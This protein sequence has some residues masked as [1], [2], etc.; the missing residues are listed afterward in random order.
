MR[1]LKGGMIVGFL[2]ASIGLGLVCALG[3][4]ASEVTPEMAKT[5]V[6]NW[7]AMREPMGCKFGKRAA[8]ARRCEVGGA[9]FNVVK[10]EEGGFVVTSAD[11]SIRPIVFF[12]DG[13]D[14]DEDP[15]NPLYALLQRDLEVCAKAAADAAAATGGTPVVPVAGAATL[16]SVKPGGSTTGTTGVSPVAGTAGTTGTT[17]VSPVAGT[18]DPTGTTGVSPVASA[19]EQ[20]WAELLSAPSAAKLAGSVTPSD[21]RVAQI[22]QSKWNQGSGIYNYYTPSN[23]VCGCVATAT[24]QLMR[25]FQYP[26]ASVASFTNPNC[27]VNGTA[28]TL[29]SQGGTFDWSNMPLV[30][31][32]PNTTQ[33]Q[34][35]GK[36]CSDVGIALSMSY[37][38]GGSGSHCTYVPWVLVNRFGYRGAV[39]VN[40]QNANDAAPMERAR[41]AMITNFDA[42]LPV[43]LGVAGN[44]GHAIVGDGYGY[45]GTNF[46]CHVNMGWSGSSDGWYIPPNIGSFT[47][48]DEVVYNIYTTQDP[49]YSIVSGR[50]L[51]SS[52]S[53]ATSQ[54]VVAKNS[55]YKVVATTTTNSK[56]IFA[57]FLQPGTY[58][59]VAESG[60]YRISASATPTAAPAVGTSVKI[61]DGNPSAAYYNNSDVCNAHVGDLKLTSTTPV[62]RIGSQNYYSFGEACYEA[63]AGQTVTLL[64]DVEETVTLTVPA[65]VDFNGHTLTGA[66]YC[67][68]NTGTAI[69][70][71]GTITNGFDGKPGVADTFPEGTV[72][73]EDMTVSGTIWSDSHPLIFAGGTYTGAIRSGS[74]ACTIIDG[75]FTSLMKEGTP[76]FVIQGGHF[77]ADFTAISSLPNQYYRWLQDATNADYPWYVTGAI[78]YATPTLADD[79]TPGTNFTSAVVTCTVNIPYRGTDGAA[80]LRVIATAANGRAYTNLVALAA[81]TGT[82]NVSTTF[83]AL[84]PAASYAVTAEV[85]FGDGSTLKDVTMDVEVMHAARKIGAWIDED[86]TTFASN[87]KWTV[88]SS[89]TSEV[90]DG[91]LKFMANNSPA[92]AVRYTPT[93]RPYD[94][95][96]EVMMRMSMRSHLSGQLPSLSPAAKVAVASVFDGEHDFFVVW[97]SGGWTTTTVSCATGAEYDILYRFDYVEQTVEVRAA[98]VGSADLESLGRHAFTTATPI[99]HID[100]AGYCELCS[101]DGDSWNAKLVRGDDGVEYATLEAAVAAGVT[102]VT[103]LWDATWNPNSK[104]RLRVLN[105]ENKALAVGNAQLPQGSR[106]IYDADTQTYVVYTRGAL[107]ILF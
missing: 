24:A 53:P 99:S 86:A 104:C 51:Q 94:C 30:P 89:A 72:R 7:R 83:A 67:Q 59:I 106:I 77:A 2:L 28:V 1:R 78:D 4:S 79:A 96:A 73:F 10:M 32:N 56:G 50:I 69:L 103:L 39:A 14:V 66:F 70:R 20:A 92:D 80:K 16:A 19:N 22:V 34:A 48:V 55:K 57:F 107:L 88:P 9:R 15:R 41:R 87:S 62:A 26:T 58:S 85:L 101:I 27:H 45:V 81:G 44:G 91:K 13:E 33:K 98:R 5:A 43:E 68:N 102:S 52:G 46:C 18:A 75:N 42:G 12:S 90:A 82:Q 3:A 6:Q 71:N 37:A 38:S 25:F 21:I 35:I 93:P 95:A 105:P 8:S 76:A 29:T 64:K 23:Y 84:M 74:T 65:T 11:T 54:T 61:A 40:W 31:S 63:A 100:F 47:I 60:N 36:L 17:G 49:S 97:S